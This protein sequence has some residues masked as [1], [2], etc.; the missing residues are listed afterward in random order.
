MTKRP[1]GVD[2]GLYVPSGSV[3]LGQVASFGIGQE[4]VPFK[5]GLDSVQL[6]F[7]KVEQIKAA[8]LKKFLSE[9]LE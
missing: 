6:R 7:T 8:A 3:Q 1:A 9:R 5:N 4:I 2:F